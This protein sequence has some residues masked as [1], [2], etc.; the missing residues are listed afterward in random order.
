[1]RVANKQG[2]I[3]IQVLFIMYLVTSTIVFISHF[4]PEFETRL[5]IAYLT[6]HVSSQLLTHFYVRE[7]Y[8]AGDSF[9]AKHNSIACNVEFGGLCIK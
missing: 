5:M 7:P 4:G 6:E 8:Y 1:M 9:I 2:C 3:A